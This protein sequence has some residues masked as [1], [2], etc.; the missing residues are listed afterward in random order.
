MFL[1]TPHRGTPFTRFGLAIAKILSPLDAGVD[2]MR[3][4]MY[5]NVDLDDLEKDFSVYFNRTARRYAYETYKLR[6]Y[7]FGVIPYI[8]E[9]V[10][11]QQ[12][13][14]FGANTTEIFSLDTDHR[15]LNKFG[16]RSS[17]Y[18]KVVRGILGFFSDPATTCRKSEEFVTPKRNLTFMNLPSDEKEPIVHKNVPYIRNA[19]FFDRPD[20]LEKIGSALNNG[21][22]GNMG[23]RSVSIVGPAGNGK[24]Q[25]ASEYIHRH[26]AEYDV[27][28][29]CNAESSIKL[30]ESIANH[31]QYL[32]IVDEGSML[33]DDQM[34]IKVKRWLVSSSTG[35]NRVKWLLMLDNVV[36]FQVIHTL[37]PS[38]GNGSILI[39]TRDSIYSTDYTPSQV[40]V[41]LL[42]NL[43]SDRFLASIIHTEQSS[44]QDELQARAVI[45]QQ[46]G[47]L[48]FSL[49]LV[50]HYVY[51]AGVSYAQFLQT[52]TRD[53][54][55]IIL[56]EDYNPEWHS[57]PTSLQV[58]LTVGQ[59]QM[60]D[61]SRQLIALFS[62]L[63]P[64][65]IPR[66]IIEIQPQAM[67][68]QG[69]SSP[70]E[71]PDIEE[72][73]RNPLTNSVKI[74]DIVKELARSSM[75]T[76]DRETCTIRMHRLTQEAIK[77]TFEEG[78]LATIFYRAV[79]RL[80]VLFPETGMASDHYGNWKECERY[81]P[82]IIALAQVYK[83]H[84]AKLGY[85]ITLCDTMLR[86]SRYLIEKH[87]FAEALSIVN[88]GI[89]MCDAA[90]SQNA[91]TGYPNDWLVPRYLS[92]LYNEKGCIEFERK[93]N[94]HGIYNWVT[95]KKIRKKVLDKFND[96]LNCDEIEIRTYESNMAEAMIENGKPR[97]AL[98]ILERI[99][100]E[101][102]STGPL[103][104]HSIHMVLALDLCYQEL[105]QLN[106]ASSS[107]DEAFGIAEAWFEPDSYIMSTGRLFL[108]LEDL[109]ESTNSYSAC[110]AILE[111]TEPNH[112]A[113]AYICHKLGYISWKERRYRVSIDFFDRA[114]QV[115]GTDTVLS[116]QALRT[117]WA[118]ATVHQEV[119]HHSEADNLQSRVNT[120]LKKHGLTE[121]AKESK[122][123]PEFFD[124]LVLHQ[125][126]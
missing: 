12:S 45:A 82:Q 63:D 39:T 25:I 20:Q 34:I 53:Y 59:M 77:K 74:N 121:K 122:F 18:D 5:D 78:Y 40:D 17:N 113:T 89:E 93:I 60:C 37:W 83:S 62:L 99:Y 61:D 51:Q 111:R 119:G 105:G 48:P 27:V 80:N 21:P 79:L 102:K 114:L 66:A 95:A 106:E 118:L 49:D 87:L 107:L 73:I 33:S 71:C 36:D 23:I 116:R 47:Y 68:D 108:K 69:P 29:W 44:M 86:C 75:V 38:G 81:A 14:T 46:Y 24:T 9:F 123:S 7:I 85:P 2:M 22:S 96:E 103:T 3:S 109:E 10:V 70:Q 124:S 110:L 84:R 26:M 76:I 58:A 1:G 42:T 55:E 32:H 28:M 101:A 120:A 115:F 4:L 30:S 43:E 19:K 64:D 67:L 94:E 88:E 125:W 72:W 50:R 112:L 92:D 98:D 11:P 91:L 104:G 56:R 100:K 90:I 97:A 16:E 31:A 41:P 15:G 57:Y 117:A 13:A 126:R 6:R 65:T 52:T 54:E 8:Q 35:A